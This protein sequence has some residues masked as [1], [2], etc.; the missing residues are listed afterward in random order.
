MRSDNIKR[1]RNSKE[2]SMEQ[3]RKMTGLSKSTI[4]DSENPNG[5][6]TEKTLKKLAEIYGVQ[7]SDFYKDNLDNDT[8]KAIANSNKLTDRQIIL[9]KLYEC[10]EWGNPALNDERICCIKWLKEQIN[11]SELKQ[12]YTFYTTETPYFKSINGKT[13]TTI[14][15]FRQI[16]SI[17][18]LFANLNNYNFPEAF[19]ALVEFIDNYQYTLHEPLNDYEK[20]LISLAIRQFEFY[21]E[22]NKFADDEN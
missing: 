12:L 10:D 1:L 13:L 7:L 22:M 2:L 5:N 18:N 9:S 15:T 8:V 6:P 21:Y 20:L 3:V 19:H 16:S 14:L 11:I 4:S 17:S